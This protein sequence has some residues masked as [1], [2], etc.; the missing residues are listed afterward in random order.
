MTKSH[1][2]L[3]E[4]LLETCF[5]LY[6]QTE[7]GLSPEIVQFSMKQS[8]TKDFSLKDLD[9]H[10]L[11][12][13]ETVE[14]LFYAHQQTKQ[15]KYREW[16]EKIFN[17]FM[18]HSRLSYA[19]FTGIRDVSSVNSTRLDRMDS[20]WFS[21]TL[22]YFFLLFDDTAAA[23]YSLDDWLFNTEAHL[24]PID[25]RQGN[26]LINVYRKLYAF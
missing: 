13:P 3:A 10:N 25:H 24:F 2:L 16:G 23:E 8:S 11:L 14:S 26:P 12:R 22:K 1:L 21:E 6:N 17:A 15:I 4:R 9:S 18:N 7:T 5:Q 20:F 19:G